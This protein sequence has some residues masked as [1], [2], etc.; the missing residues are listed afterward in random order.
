VE[1]YLRD[2]AKEEAVKDNS[3]KNFQIIHFACHSFLDE[4]FPFRSALVLTLDNDPREDG[5]L[6][7]RE[8]FTLKLNADLIVLS[9]CQTGKGRIER[10]E[11]IFVL[12]RIFFYSGARSVLST[13]W[14]INDKSTSKFMEYF[15]GYLLQGKNKAEALRSAKLKMINT[16]YPHPFYWAPFILNGVYR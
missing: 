16:Q 7:A 12:P 1:I 3:L 11:G 6:Q 9:A 2:K 8:I 15:Y 5:F 13:L 4:K 10:G 14:T